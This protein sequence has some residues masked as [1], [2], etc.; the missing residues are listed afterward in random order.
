M[1]KY[2]LVK[3]ADDDATVHQHQES[4]SQSQSRQTSL[5]ASTAAS[6][7]TSTSTT[8]KA[9]QGIVR[10]T[11]QG[12]PRNYISYAMKLFVSRSCRNDWRMK[13]SNFSLNSLSVKR[14]WCSNFGTTSIDNNNINPVWSVHDIF[15]FFMISTSINFWQYIAFSVCIIIFFW[16]Q[17]RTQLVMMMMMIWRMIMITY[18]HMYVY[19]YMPLL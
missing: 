10:I 8:G 9:N 19:I 13:S 1:D 4:Q 5:D 16:W 14:I 18:M 3:S 12:K 7:S 6:V 17:Q 2:R 15:F 11:Q